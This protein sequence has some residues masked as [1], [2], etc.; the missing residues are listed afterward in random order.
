MTSERILAFFTLSF[1][2]FSFLSEIIWWFEQK[3][4]SL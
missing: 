3:A 2:Y 1:F 4:V